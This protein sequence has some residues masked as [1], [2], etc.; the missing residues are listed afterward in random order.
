MKS[1]KTTLSGVG[2][3]CMAVGN[4]ISEYVAG[5]KAGVNYGVLLTGI[6]TGIGLLFA[7]DSNVTGGSVLQPSTPQ[8]TAEQTAETKNNLT[9]PVVVKP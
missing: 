9:A 8:V 2:V 5:G 7:K 1:Y 4:A 3:I 6:V